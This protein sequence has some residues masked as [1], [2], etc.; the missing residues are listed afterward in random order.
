MIVGLARVSTYEQEAGMQAQ[1]RDLT[2][3]GCERV[4]AEQVSALGDR[5]ELRAMLDFVREGDVAVVTKPCRLAR[6]TTDLLKIVEA[7]ET[8][9]VGLRILSMG[10]AELDTRT[11]TGRLL[12][13]LTAAVAEFERSLMLER[14]REG[15][16][17]AKRENRYKGRAPTAQRQTDSILR[18]SADG[19]RPTEIAAL[20][21][22]SRASAY[23]IIKA[24]KETSSARPSRP[25]ASKSASV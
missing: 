1:L 12:L 5:V 3:A 19:L 25:P 2:A 8:K 21:N 13:T 15:V 14:Q 24:A 7:L 6:S 9:K 20:L 10:G 22:I 16:E 23:S 18:L 4:F 17:K 11:P